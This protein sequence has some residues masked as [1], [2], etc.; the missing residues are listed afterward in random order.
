M[1]RRKR[2]SSSTEGGRDEQRKRHEL[3]SKVQSKS[4]KLRKSERPEED[5][6]RAE[7][8]SE[9]K[10]SPRAALTSC[11]PSSCR[12][13]ALTSQRDLQPCLCPCPW[14][15]RLWWHQLFW[16]FA[17]LLGRSFPSSPSP[18]SSCLRPTSSHPAWT[19]PTKRDSRSG[20][21]SE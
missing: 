19:S 11:H 8:E 18:S 5:T 13:A 10:N 9:P 2:T 17:F 1:R 20:R 3:T 15:W 21:V 12:P 16:P 4:Y 14:P 6:E 7:A